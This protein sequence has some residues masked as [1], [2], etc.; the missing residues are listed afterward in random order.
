MISSKFLSYGWF[1]KLTSQAGGTELSNYELIRDTWKVRENT[2]PDVGVGIKAA[3]HEIRRKSPN[4]TGWRCRQE[5]AMSWDIMERRSEVL[6]CWHLLRALC[7][8]TLHG[9]LYMKWPLLLR[10]SP[11][12]ALTLC[13]SLAKAN[14][15][16]ACRKTASASG[17]ICDVKHKIKFVNKITA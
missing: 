12:R 11:L 8:Y 3:F 7:C 17:S 13:Y 9:I 14:S 5:W 2:S 4:T 16:S 10:C 15:Q 1:D 6:H